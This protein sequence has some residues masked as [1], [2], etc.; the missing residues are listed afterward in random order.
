VDLGRPRA[1]ARVLLG[2]LVS[3]PQ[4]LKL[5]R[6]RGDGVSLASYAIVNVSMT[7]FFV[8]AVAIRDAVSIASVPA[9]MV[10]NIQIATTLLRRR[11][12]S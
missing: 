2:Q 8:H 10:A 5:R 4:V 1:G 12:L 9:S 11:R 3:W 6:E 7:P